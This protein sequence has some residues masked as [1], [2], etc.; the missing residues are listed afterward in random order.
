MRDLYD[1]YLPAFK[2][3]VV[4]AKVESV[5][6]AYNRT[7]GVPCSASKLLLDDILR[8]EWGFEG[9]V[10]SDCGA[11]T[12]IFKH[13]KYTAD[14]AEAAAA[15][16][17][18]GCD[19]GCDC[20]YYD[21]LA[22]AVERG[23][24]TEEEID[25]SLA[26]TLAT[27]FKLGMFDPD[28]MVPFASIPE[29]V[30]NCDEHRQL[31]YKAATK[32]VVLL[33]NRNNILPIQP[34]TMKSILVI[35]PNAGSIDILLGNYHGIS[36]T[37]TTLVAAIAGRVPEG[38]KCDYHPGT[39]LTVGPKEKEVDWTVFNA[40]QADLVI[41]CMGIAP[42]IEGEEG[43]AMLSEDTGDRINIGLPKAQADYVKK[44]CQAG[45]KVVLVLAAGSPL[46]LGELED[47]VEAVVYVWYPGQE[48]G[49]AVADVLFGKVAPSGK[50]P[51]TFP[52]SVDQL[53][54]FEDYNMPGH[55]YR[56]AEWEPLYPFGFGLSYTTFAYSNLR[57]N[58]TELKAGEPLEAC[59]TVT[60]TGKVDAEEVVQV[61]LKDLEASVLVPI[62]SLVDFQRIAL[63]AGE[64]K[65]VSFTIEADKMMLY[66]E[67][68]KQKLEPGEFRITIGGC[69]PSE[70]GLALGAPEPVTG[71]FVV[72]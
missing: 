49:D 65:D 38:V 6:S 35:G 23:L 3:L 61:Y 20:V 32:T 46:T 67:D 47:M 53:P 22:E 31:A 17:K 28:E 42:T 9:H 55:T 18:A 13:H 45:A 16:L 66:D 52:K 7:L 54:P 57:L 64:S 59:V 4:D 68:G 69:S 58:K 44:L 15:A 48:G 5:M 27:R 19:I 11:L 33:K 56:Y 72:V 26:R 30:I 25:V 40:A 24:V 50:L 43:A 12:D 41:A 63:K 34:E 37:L 71:T 21:H 62:N 1:T 8:K 39:A 60:N 51:L 70:R 10:V 14:G 29:S 36:D 2:K